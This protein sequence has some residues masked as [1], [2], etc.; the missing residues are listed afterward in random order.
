[1]HLQ[2]LNYKGSAHAHLIFR[3]KKG[4]TYVP[5]YYHNM[6]EIEGATMSGKPINYLYNSNE[7]VNFTGAGY[8]SFRKEQVQC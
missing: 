2:V 4:N 7:F 8:I 5:D 6:Y 1:M 3:L